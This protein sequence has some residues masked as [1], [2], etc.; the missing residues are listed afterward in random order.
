MWSE[1]WKGTS[2]GSTNHHSN[3]QIQNHEEEQEG[4]VITST[5]K[6]DI[7]LRTFSA[8]NKEDTGKIHNLQVQWPR[9]GCT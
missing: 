6:P 1:T 3:N 2:D 9:E 4:S 7:S 5:L 8:D